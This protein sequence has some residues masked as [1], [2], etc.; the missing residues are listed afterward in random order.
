MPLYLFMPLSWVNNKYSIQQVQ[1]TQSM[2][3][4]AV[5][6]SLSTA[7]TTF[8]MISTLTDF[9]SQMVSHFSADY[10]LLNSLQSHNSKLTNE[11]SQSSHCTTF[12][13]YCLRIVRLQV[14]PQSRSVMS[15]KSI[16]INARSELPSACPNWLIYGLHLHTI[17]ASKC[18]A[19][20][21]ESQPWSVTISSHDYGLQVSMIIACKWAFPNSIDYGLEVCLQ[22]HT[23]IIAVCVSKFTGSWTPCVS[24]NSHNNSVQ[25]A[26]S[27]LPGTSPTWMLMA[28]KCVSVFTPLWLLCVSPIRLDFNLLVRLHTRSI[29]ASKCISYFTQ[30]WC[31]ETVQLEGSQPCISTSPLLPWLP[32]GILDQDHIWPKELWKR[33]GG[34]EGT[35]GYDEWQ[36]LLGS[37]NAWEACV[38]NHTTGVKQSKLGKIAWNIKLR[39]IQCIFH[40]GRRCISTP[41]SPK[42][43]LHITMSIRVVPIFPCI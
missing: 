4:H 36:K 21:T 6:H 30:S 38:R 43:I 19:L 32:N 39:Q 24:S 5:Q 12:P 22:T 1:H 20:L 37:M 3:L 11:H 17:R 41:G 34:N 31:G 18:I 16:S 25:L 29:T 13:N 42:Y 2:A 8:C 9:H 7:Y 35:T 15:S 28:S 26:H 40:I 33:V 14:L 27:R 23:I 10:E